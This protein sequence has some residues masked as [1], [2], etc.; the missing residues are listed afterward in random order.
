MKLTSGGG[1][2]ET[3]PPP[4]QVPMKKTIVNVD[5]LIGYLLNGSNPSE[6][7]KNFKKFKCIS[8]Q[9]WQHYMNPIPGGGTLKPPRPGAHEDNVKVDLLIGYLSNGS[10][11]SKSHKNEFIAMF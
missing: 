10:N 9:T 2:F 4:P 6:T 7:H 11:P 3:P 5:L 8:R 1:Y